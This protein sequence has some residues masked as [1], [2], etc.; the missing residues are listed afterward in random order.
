MSRRIS[1][2]RLNRAREIAHT[3]GAIAAA[4][5]LSFMAVGAAAFAVLMVQLNE[6]I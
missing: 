2:I 1:S 3:V 4:V 6:K 5:F